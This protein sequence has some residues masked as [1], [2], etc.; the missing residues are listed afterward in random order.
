MSPIATW[1]S[2]HNASIVQSFPKM[3]CM[4]PSHDQG[5]T[6]RVVRLNLRRKSLS[7]VF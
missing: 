6:S 5:T 7:F 1:Y 3:R 2:C 4:A